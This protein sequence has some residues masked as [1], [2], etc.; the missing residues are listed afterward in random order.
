MAE[1]GIGLVGSGFMGRCHALAFRAAPG[2]FDL[3][4]VPRLEFLADID[5]AAAQTAARALGFARAT[6]DWRTLIDDPRVQL[7]DITTPTFLHEA[8]VRAA[9]A[10]GKDI[11]CEKPLAPSAATAKALVDAAEAAGVKT[12]VGFNYLKNPITALAREIIAGGEIGEVLAF[13]GIH[14]EDYMADP[15]APFTWRLDPANGPGA[16][17]D[18]GSHITAMARFLLGDITE[19]CGQTD[20]VIAERPSGAGASRAVEVDDQAQVLLRFASGASGTLEAGGQLGG[21]RPQDAAGLRDRRQPRIARLHPGAPERAQ[22]LDRRAGQG[23]G[24]LQDRHRR[25]RSS[26]LRRLLPGAWPSARLQRPEDNRSARSDRR[27]R[28]RRGALAG[29]PRG[30]A[31]AKGDRR[32]GPLGGGA[33]LGAS[34]GGLRARARRGP[35]VIVNK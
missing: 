7:V 4:L 1:V 6:G 2:L 20:T 3:P 34:R 14:A 35:D 30:L 33:P 21:Q 31:G 26:W 11:Y 15:A 19:V 9:V 32:G 18:L 25:A 27:A 13:R 22:G 5:Q 28:R 29:L 12:M 17:G 16:I 8:M 10:A 23:P 24:R